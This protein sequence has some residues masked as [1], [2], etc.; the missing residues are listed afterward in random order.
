MQLKNVF[1]ILFLALGLT[2]CSSVQKVVY[3]IDVPQGNYLEEV[4][5]AKVQKGMTKEQ[6]QYL[7]GTPVLENPFNDSSWYY[8]FMQQK[9]YQAPEQYTFTVNFDK[10]NK[11]TDFIL[12]KALPKDPKAGVNNTIISTKKVQPKGSL[13]NW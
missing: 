5:V 7:L 3:R 9:A 10:Q 12:S 4:Q 13:F 6:V 8:V 11:V 2:A 1:P